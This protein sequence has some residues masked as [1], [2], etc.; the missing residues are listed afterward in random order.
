[1]KIQTVGSAIKLSETLKYLVKTWKDI[2]DNTANINRVTD[3]SAKLK[4]VEMDCIFKKN[5]SLT[6]F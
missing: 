3:G 6:V 4:K 5:S 1:M 2:T